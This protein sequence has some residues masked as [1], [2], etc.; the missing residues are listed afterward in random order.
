M[1]VEPTRDA[2]P[3]RLCNLDRLEP[4]TGLEPATS[5]LRKWRTTS[6]ASTAGGSGGTRTRTGSVLS[7]VPLPLGYGAWYTRQDSNLR[8]PVCETGVLAA[9]PRMLALEVGIEPTL[10]GL[11]PAALPLSYSSWYAARESNP[12]PTA[13]KTVVQPLHLRRW[14]VMRDSNPRPLRCQRSALAD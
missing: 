2:W 1:G 10:T 14:W 13:Y 11:Q 7:A 9:R 8:S 6:C 12:V 3:S 5:T 4:S